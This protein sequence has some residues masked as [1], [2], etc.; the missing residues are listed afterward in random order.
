[1]EQNHQKRLASL[2]TASML[3]AVGVTCMFGFLAI[4]K[5]LLTSKSDTGLDAMCVLSLVGLVVWVA[6]LYMASSSLKGGNDAVAA[7]FKGFF[8]AQ[9]GIVIAVVV[10]YALNEIVPKMM[11]KGHEY[12]YLYYGSSYKKV[13]ITY[14]VL[15][16]LFIG[17]LIVFVAKSNIKSRALKAA[18]LKSMGGI[19]VAFTII[20]VVLSII[21]LIFLAGLTDAEAV[22]KFLYGMGEGGLKALGYL[23]LIAWLA[24]D[25]LMIIGWW[26]VRS[27]LPKMLKEDNA[28]TDL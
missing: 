13:M 6:G 12:D 2:S 9:L 24:A 23:I 18:G 5:L 7:H 8:Y 1:M 25:V 19:S 28:G 20:I 3:S 22:F 15:L 17:S 27:E 14:S 21:A 16:L 10:Y 4:V 26:S 11:M